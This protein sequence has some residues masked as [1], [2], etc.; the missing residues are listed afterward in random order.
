MLVKV[1]SYSQYDSYAMKIEIPEGDQLPPQL[2]E[3]VNREAKQNRKEI[4]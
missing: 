4:K 3:R 1:D 2:L